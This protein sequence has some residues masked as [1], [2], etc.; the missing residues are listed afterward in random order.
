MELSPQSISTEVLQSK[1]C[2]G[3]ESTIADNQRRVAQALAQ[4]ENAPEKWE[5]IFLD[6][7]QRGMVMAGRIKSAA[8]T[9]PAGHL[10]QLLRAASR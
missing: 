4:V 9:R 7:M 1:Y 10:D 3:A 6:A 8:G 5:P 2:K